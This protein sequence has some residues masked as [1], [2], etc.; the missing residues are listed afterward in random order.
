MFSL[1]QQLYE[2]DS[3][4]LFIR[5][6]FDKSTRQVDIVFVCST[7]LADLSTLVDRNFYALPKATLEQHLGPVLRYSRTGV[8][9]F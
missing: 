3:R 5:H 9:K 1:E 7:F 2:S 4:K 8:A 6:N